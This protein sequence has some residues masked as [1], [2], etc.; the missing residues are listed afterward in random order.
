MTWIQAMAMAVSVPG[1]TCSTISERV[2]SHVMRGST[3]MSF[4]PNW[5]IISMTAWPYMPSG[6][7]RRGSLPHST[8]TSGG[9]NSSCSYRSANFWA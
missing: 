2:P 4:V 8:T 5:R 6:L 3:Q 7:E 1:F 9:T